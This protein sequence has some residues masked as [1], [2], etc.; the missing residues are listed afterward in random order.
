MIKLD[1][2]LKYLEENGSSWMP[3]SPDEKFESDLCK[4]VSNNVT[5]ITHPWFKTAEQECSQVLAGKVKEI[6]EDISRIDE[7]IKEYEY[8]F[9]IKLA[10]EQKDGVRMMAT[11]ML[12][13]LTGGPGT[14]KT[15]VLKCAVYVI[16]RLNSNTSICFTAPTGKAARRI[17]EGAGF[18]ATTIQKKIHDTGL[19]NNILD[20]IWED[21]CIVDESSMLDLE[22]FYKLCKCLSSHTRLVLVGDVDQLPSVGE[23]SILRDLLNSNYIPAVML[24]KTF[25]QDNSSKLFENI[26][27]VKKGCNVPLEEGND[28]KRFKESGDI[29]KLCVDR[30]MENV[31]TYGVEQTVLLSPYRKAGNVCSKKLNSYLQRRLNPDGVGF[32]TKV[33]RDDSDEWIEFKVGDPVINLRNNSRIANGDTGRIIF[34]GKGI[35]KVKFSDCTYIYN[36]SR[37]ELNDL[38]LAYALS[39]NKSQG[40]EY[41]CVIVPFLKEHDNLSRNMIYTAISRAKSI[42]EVIGDDE[43]IQSACKTQAAMERNSFLAEEIETSMKQKQLIVDLLQEA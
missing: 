35:V 5:Y 32:K 23:G 6:K 40:S 13:I 42:C 1:E 16:K 34:I 19:P 43:V 41:K 38:D 17:K 39:V 26:Q 7:Y 11:Q 25:R 15:S 37:Q 28:F 27:I 18:E 29:F 22:V 10:D 24:E 30:Y 8:A 9:N 2:V 33:W 3:I 14:G 12:C 36:V 21:V 4:R 31:K 20:D